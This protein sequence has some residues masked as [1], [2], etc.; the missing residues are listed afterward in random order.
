[1]L[2]VVDV[3]GGVIY[4]AET[5]E[6]GQLRNLTLGLYPELKAGS[7]R[8]EKQADHVLPGIEAC[9]C[10]L[11]NDVRPTPISAH[12]IRL[13]QTWTTWSSAIYVPCLCSLNLCT[14]YRCPCS[15]DAQSSL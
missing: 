9:K 1:M 13:E 14:R 10:F 15:C 12:S 5:W 7:K 4:P 2:D 8:L 6:K 11:S 3:G